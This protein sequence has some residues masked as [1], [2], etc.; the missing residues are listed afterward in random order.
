ML[1]INNSLS[2]RKLMDCE[3]DYKLLYKWLND[4]V[5]Q[6]FYEG[7]S[8]KHTIEE[9]YDEFR[10]RAIGEDYVQSCIIKFEKEAIGYLQFYHLQQEE[11]E[12]YGASRYEQVYG[13]DL[14]IGEHVYW[15]K[16]IGTDVMKLTLHYLFTMQGVH[17]VFID[18]QTWNERAI[19]CYEKCGFQ[20]IKVLPKRELHDGEYKDNQIMRITHEEFTY[21]L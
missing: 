2:I 9:I 17:E 5:V 20:K 8:V 12:E 13:I 6:E 7:K 19:A 1:A 21:P 4:E 18:P 11:I 16:G 3:A 14:F 15:N 10:P